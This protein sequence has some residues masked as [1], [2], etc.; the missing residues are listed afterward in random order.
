MTQLSQTALGAWS[1]GRFMRFGE[2]IDDDRFTAIMRPDAAIPTVITADVY[3]TGDADTAVGKALSGLSRDSYNLVGAVGHDFI[4]G[5]RRGAKG[6]PRFTDPDLRGPEGYAD[7][8]KRSVEASL[9]RCGTDHFDLLLLHNPDRIGFTSEAVWKALAEIRDEGL[10]GSLGVAPGP[11]NG[12][13]LDL[14]SCLELHG[15]LV[16]WAMLIL[17]PLEPWPAE[18][19]LPACEAHGTKVIARVAD[20]GGLFHGDIRP[21]HPFR[22]HDHRGF[23]PAGWV[24]RGT[25]K[26]A[27][28]A[29]IREATGLTTL[30]LA[31]AWNLAHPAVECVV[32]TLIQEATDTC[33]TIEQQRAD[34]ASLPANAGRILNEDQFNQIREIGENQGCMKLKGASPDHEGDELA[35]CWSIND[36]LVD[37]GARWNVEPK[38]LAQVPMA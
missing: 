31:C 7:Y 17:N 12:F 6:F 19:S 25:G 14:I 10:A 38:D 30:Q 1:G 4:N 24:E 16:D 5:E 33:K 35:D 18:L 11:A 8:L 29:D 37:F 15:E 36:Q 32:P 27:Q 28:M 2:P 34:L 26:I 21:G 3:G 13:V 20:H 22:E 23:R 9:E